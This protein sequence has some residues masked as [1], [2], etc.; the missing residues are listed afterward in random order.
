MRTR[1]AGLSLVE[2][3]VAVGI[4]GILAAIAMPRY[5]SFLVQAR[6]GEAKSNLSHLASLQEMYKVEH[7]KYYD[8]PAMTGV[9]GVG[10]MDGSGNVGNC[11]DP[12]TGDD[13]GLANKLGFR[14]DNCDG[15]RYFYQFANSGATIIASAASDRNKRFIYPDCSGYHA[16]EECGYQYGD[17]VTLAMSDGKPTVCRNITK[18]CPLGV[19]GRWGRVVN[20]SSSSSNSYSVSSYPML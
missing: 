15:L 6:R 12:N 1:I 18:Y 14:P 5:K 7:F 2:L 3:M 8:G 4:V 20:S 13:E 16:Q 17:A 11:S 19:G 10:Y 9:N